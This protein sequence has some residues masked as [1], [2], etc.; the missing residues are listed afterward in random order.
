MPNDDGGWDSIMEK[1][2]GGVSTSVLFF[3]CWFRL[4]MLVF[5]SF[6]NADILIGLEDLLPRTTTD[7]GEKKAPTALCL[8][9]N[10]LHSA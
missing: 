1:S 10:C 3:Y 9:N 6:Q 7:M 2:A 4:L 5:H 8:A